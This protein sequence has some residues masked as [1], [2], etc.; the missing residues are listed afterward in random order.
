MPDVKKVPNGAVQPQIYD[1][2]GEKASHTPL[3]KTEYAE[4]IILFAASM[5]FTF[6]LAY[7]FSS[8]VQKLWDELKEGKKI[9]ILTKDQLKDQKEIYNGNQLGKKILVENKP[10]K[11]EPKQEPIPPLVVNQPKQKPIPPAIV[12]PPKKDLIPP[13]VPLFPP[14]IVNQQPKKEPAKLSEAGKVAAQQLPNFEKLQGHFEKIKS[15]QPVPIGGSLREYFL[16]AHKGAFDFEVKPVVIGQSTFVSK[17][18]TAHLMRQK[19]DSKLGQK[20]VKGDK[21][22]NM[23]G[24][25]HTFVTPITPITMSGDYVYKNKHSIN[26]IGNGQGRNVVLSAAIQPDFELGGKDEVIMKIVEAQDEPIKGE[27]LAYDYNPLQMRQLQDAVADD[28]AKLAQH[29][30][31][32]QEHMIYH[33]TA[34]H[35][36]P[37]KKE[38]PQDCIQTVKEQKEYLE[39][40]INL[41]NND[42]DYDKCLKPFYVNING[43]LVSME[44]LYN[45]YLNQIRNEFT[46]LEALL[47]QG[48]VYTIN[49]PSIFA[50]QIG[51]EN[52]TLLNRLQLLALK[53]LHHLTPLDNLKVIGFADY[54]DKEAV[55]L[56]QAVFPQKVVLSKNEV[57]NKN[58]KYSIEQ[59]YALVIHNNSDAFGQNIET[60]GPT[61]LDGVIGSYSNAAVNL[62]RDRKDLLN[63]VVTV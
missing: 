24:A 6:G 50:A 40:F 44:A 8:K 19:Q 32:L 33:L 22:T 4:R 38:I 61:S 43:H 46:V 23:E 17:S 48:Y 30:K 15:N 54:A 62:K 63:N 56:Y 5:F 49:P 26:F 47:P 18:M 1:Y 3:N 27:N 28:E 29:E 36:L 25:L 10:Q 13:P 58:G 60:E 39:G 9:T 53:K 31:R 12:N 59:D 7:V 14:P 11:P 37:A 41:D 57:F 2:K 21:I 51:K 52:V 34:D 55:K 35:R 16:E 45:L 20:W 42:L